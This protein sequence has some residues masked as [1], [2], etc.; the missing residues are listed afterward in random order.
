MLH[1]VLAPGARSRGVLVQEV[2]APLQLRAV[3]LDHE[4][5]VHLG[6]PLPLGHHCGAHAWV[7][8]MHVQT[9]PV[10]ARRAAHHH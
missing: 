5:Q 9:A 2:R 10:S 3:D 8:H 7:V 6:I 1:A 4:L